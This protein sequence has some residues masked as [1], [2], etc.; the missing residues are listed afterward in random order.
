MI[1]V[2]GS[3]GFLGKYVVDRL[4]VRGPVHCVVRAPSQDRFDEL[5]RSR[6]G[7]RAQSLEGDLGSELLGVDPAELRGIQHLVHIA[8]L[9]DLE[10]P[11][12]ACRAANE[13]GT[14]HALALATALGATFHH[15]STIA[16]AGDID[17]VFAEH[18]FDRGQRHGH[19]YA[20][21]KFEAEALVRAHQGPWRIYR[22][23]MIVG[24][25]QTGESDKVDGIG[26]LFPLI[27]ALRG[28]L[29]AW[30]PLIGYEG[31]ALPLAPVD[32]VASAIETLMFLP[33]QD[34]QTFHL[35]D[36]D[37]PTLGQAANLIA[38]AAHAP[39]FAVRITPE[40][41]ENF[42]MVGP[43]L[44]GL[45]PVKRARKKYLGGAD[46]GPMLRL[47][48]GRTQ[49]ASVRTWELL[50]AE[51]VHCPPFASYVAALWDH[52]D[53]VLRPASAE[54]LEEAVSGRVVVVTGASSGI[55]EEV[56]RVL[57][58]NGAHTVLV[59]RSA[60]KLKALAG[61][62]REA[63]GTATVL[64]CDLADPESIE[65]LILAVE[66]LGGCDVLINNAGRSIRRSV[67]DSSERFHDFERTMQLNYFGALRLILGFLPGMRARGRGHV[68]NILSMGL[69]TRVPR[70]AAYIASKAALEAASSSMH[71]EVLHDGVHFTSV[72][73]PLVR[74][75][76]IA[77]SALYKTWPALEVH[78]AAA[79]VTQA[80][81]EKPARVSTSLG[82]FAAFVTQ[83][84]PGMGR[85][86]LNRGVRLVPVDANSSEQPR[87]GGLIGKIL[88]SMTT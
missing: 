5:N 87:G 18:D 56:A 35:V 9:Y 69:Q 71:A 67:A 21:S 53:R 13:Q 44:R 73:M 39:R 14:A 76:M 41:F 58:S 11:E 80:I 68:V 50:D 63:G 77:P 27:R 60:D 51:G 83:V 61:E 15:I 1:L 17:G 70:Y 82:S 26:M 23:A 66:N 25:A 33:G 24:C 45:P 81:T 16:V 86:V 20:R 30:V 64:P 48:S 32:F 46:G 36:P 65:E 54:T 40:F 75:P 4:V 8:A 47:V 78:E 85:R 74:T 42:P 62:I 22:P 37:P 10:A 6:W 55:G 19:P 43:L 31:A 52:W 59:A 12:D 57:A 34:G 7:G 38:K 2:T 29:P 72:Y 28:A 88:R 79:M 3:T 84:A 49:I